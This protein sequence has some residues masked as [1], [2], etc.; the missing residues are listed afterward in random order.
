M[1]IGVSNMMEDDMRKVEGLLAQDVVNHI[2]VYKRYKLAMA[3]S[4]NKVVLNNQM[5]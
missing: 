4:R 2:D 1:A 5:K 3:T